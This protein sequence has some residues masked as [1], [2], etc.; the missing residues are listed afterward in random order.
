MLHTQVSARPSGQSRT[1]RERLKNS[2]E[3]QH[4]HGQR[5]K[6]KDNKNKNETQKQP[7]AKVMNVNV[8]K[9]THARNKGINSQANHLQSKVLQ[10]HNKSCCLNFFPI[11]HMDDDIIFCIKN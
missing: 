7:K 6:S 11:I 9:V 8:I 3:M 5:D 4:I 2:P 1:C 10:Y